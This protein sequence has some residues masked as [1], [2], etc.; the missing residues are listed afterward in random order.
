MQI[1]SVTLTGRLGRDPEAKHFDS[2]AASVK[3]SLAVDRPVKDA[4][5]DW[6]ECVAWGK[7]GE[8]IANYCNK[9]SLIGV[10][11][12]IYQETWEDSISGEKRSKQVVKVENVALLGGKSDGGSGGNGGNS[13]GYHTAV[14]TS[15]D[16][17]DF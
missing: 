2:G 10:S 7:T 14:V 1:N 4:K 15:Y 16:Y 11:G 12:S 3:F 17:D 6:F 5:P 8:V 9:G 13:G